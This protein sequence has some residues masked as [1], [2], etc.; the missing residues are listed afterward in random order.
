MNKPGERQYLERRRR[1]SLA[2]AEAATDPAIARIHRDFAQHY[3]AAIEKSGSSEVQDATE[4]S[5][6]VA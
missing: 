2:A 3:T 5:T 4:N 6:T 1:D